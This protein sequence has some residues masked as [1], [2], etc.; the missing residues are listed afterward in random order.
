[1]MAVNMEIAQVNLHHAAAASAVITSR[2]TAEKLGTLLIQEPWIH[3]GEVKGLKTEA[4]KVIWDLSSERPRTCIV[5]RSN[6]DFFCISEFLTQDLVA[7]QARDSE[8]KD[9]VLASAYFPGEAAT[10]PAEAVERLV[11]HCRLHK[12]PLIIGCD[13]NAH[14]TEWGSTDCNAR[15]ESLLE[16]LVGRNLAV[17]NVGCEPTFVTISRREVLDI[18]LSNEP[19]TGMVSQWRVSTEPSLSDHRI[20][21]FV[22]RAEVKLFPPRRNPRRT[23][24]GTFKERLDDELRRKGQTDN[25]ATEAQDTA[26]Y[27]TIGRTI[28]VY[29][30]LTILGLQPQDLPASRLHTIKA[31]VALTKVWSTCCFHRKVE[32]RCEVSKPG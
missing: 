4:N 22:L 1:M 9:F 7:V 20:V 18:T 6:I 16:Y 26:P 23:N 15:G 14:H 32:S 28:M 19:A 2:F 11:E 3:K 13:A 10:A 25:S 12:L 24:W 30:H 17:E 27:V 21:R 8:G 5:V 31:F 29:N